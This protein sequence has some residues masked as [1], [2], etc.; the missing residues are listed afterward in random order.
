MHIFAQ[1]LVCPGQVTKHYICREASPVHSGLGAECGV[2]HVLMPGE[3]F[4]AFE[5]PKA[6]V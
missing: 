6:G 4:M 3:A 5:D 2:L 1:H